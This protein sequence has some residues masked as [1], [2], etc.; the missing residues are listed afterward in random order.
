MPFTPDTAAP[1]PAK[2]GGFVPDVP[3]EPGQLLDPSQIDNPENRLRQKE[4]IELRQSERARAAKFAK[5][6]QESG[7]PLSLL[8][9]L[10]SVIRA[11]VGAEPSLDKQVELL[12]M[13]PG[14]IKTR[15]SKDGTNVIARITG[16]DGRAKD[17][18][19]HPFGPVTLG[20]VAG[21]AV[22][23]A[24]GAAMAGVAAITTPLS[25]PL[26]AGVMGMT[27]AGME[28]AGTSASRLLAGQK[29]DAGDVLTRAREEATL[30]AALPLALGAG[31]KTIEGA[32]ALLRRN[33]SPL[34]QDAVSA[35]GRR[36]VPLFP[37]QVADSK[38]LARAE[39]MAGLGELNAEQ[40]AALRTS[41]DREIG[42]NG[43]L[44]E[45]TIA[46]KIQPIFQTD[47]EA[48]AKRAAI[49]MTDAE[50]AAQREITSQLDSGL[51]PSGV[52]NTAVGQHTRGK[53]DEFVQ[54]V[55]DAAARDYPLFHAKA[56]EEGIT[57]DPAPISALVA[58]IEKEDP[59]AVADLLVP[60]VKQV[61]GVE[62]RL[63]APAAEAQPAKFAGFQQ[64]SP[65][66]PEIPAPPLTFDEAIRQRK[67]V[68]DKLNT[69]DDPLSAGVKTYFKQLEKA[70]TDSINDGLARG[71]PEMRDLYETARS[72]YKKGADLLD[73]GVVQKIFR[74]PGQAGRV[75]DENVVTQLFT[76]DGKLE[77]LRDMK[78]ILG[79]GSPDYK[80]LI[81]QGVQNMID[82]AAQKGSGG[83]IDVNTFLGKFNN[84]S[85]EMRAEMFGPLEAPL[86]ATADAMAIAQKGAASVA[87]IPANEL[88]DAL[89]AA[90]GS[91]KTLINQGVARQKAYE[92]EY[93]NGIMSRL[94][95]GKLGIKGLGNLDR[96]VTDFVP[97]A[98]AVDMR[99]ILT[100]LEA[101][102]PGSTE[103]IRA[104]VLTNIRN[105][106]VSPEGFI[107][108]A[109]AADYIKDP[110]Y[111]V[112]LGD[113]GISFLDDM[114]TLAKSNAQ[115]VERG[116][117]APLTSM[118]IGTYGLA[119]AAGATVGSKM[120]IPGALAGAATPFLKNVPLFALGKAERSAA[121]RDFL[122]TG[123]IPDLGWKG[124]TA[125]AALLASPE[126]ETQ[127][128]RALTSGR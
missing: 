68:R 45:S 83:L 101:T 17:V 46:N 77:A 21:A 30:N 1:A 87:K 23:I 79:A 88:A 32:G 103:Q 48:A 72:G 115:R 114:A 89:L 25:L 55:K 10:P 51:V 91:V 121:V 70:Y 119:A 122:S 8:D 39:G 124:Q 94:T 35:S 41:F 43:V 127:R 97:Q 47:A 19:L 40:Q 69:P 81:R 90:P 80:L 71:S 113:G 66:T 125:R 5:D 3:S 109:K 14:I 65:A 102:S 118:G 110:K 120:G 61:K 78:Q 22:P 60:A 75:P 56:A 15:P 96:F 107:D 100:R 111:R 73:K 36:S 4:T 123:K 59:H 9:G 85:K 74:E 54:N 82:A 58:K 98:S 13:Q 93:L 12:G 112:I 28:A 126:A 76:G 7:T 42:P 20:D 34:A 128:E 108:P 117:A 49:T 52:S 38:V 86:K 37:S 63:T 62:T 57:L 116:A 16:D 29:L 105:D 24:K 11:R 31:G 106:L 95:G 104:R 2:R 26:A 64:V 18:L 33:P 44:R 50:K 27:A 53:F 67:I 99:Q 6:N 84:L 92:T